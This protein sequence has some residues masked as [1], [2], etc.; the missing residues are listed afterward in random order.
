LSD[1]TFA[2]TK[3]E[4]R[5]RGVPIGCILYDDPRG[6][7][8]YR[9]ENTRISSLAWGHAGVVILPDYQLVDDKITLN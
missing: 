1:R 2:N 8:L 6:P 3:E 5:Q 4:A 9:E 7:G